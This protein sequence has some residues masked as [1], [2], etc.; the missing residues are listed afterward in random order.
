[1]QISYPDLCPTCAAAGTTKTLTMDTEKTPLVYGCS[2]GHAFEE[3]PSA[4]QTPAEE[5][6]PPPVAQAVGESRP[7]AE[8]VQ[9]LEKS[10]GNEPKPLAFGGGQEESGCEITPAEL[11]AVPP[12]VKAM[13]E[14]P[15]VVGRVAAAVPVV[16][17]IR[18]AMAA[19]ERSA[20]PHPEDVLKEVLRLGVVDIGAGEKLVVVRLPERVAVDVAAQA[21]ETDFREY[22][23]ALMVCAFDFGWFQN[24]NVQ[25]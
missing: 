19:K 1:M 7:I 10:A 20:R 23:N 22:F 15:P 21:G 25:V 13:L 11:A 3:L 4:T 16:E 12:R 24:L 17:K 14:P 6:P 9:E 8:I 2:A 5:L 18:E